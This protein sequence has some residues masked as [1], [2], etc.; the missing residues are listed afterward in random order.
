MLFI[1]ED[2]AGPGGLGEQKE[3][4]GLIK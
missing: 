1:I 4:R 2:F 3:G